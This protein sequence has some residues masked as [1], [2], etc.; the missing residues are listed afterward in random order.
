MGMKIL[1]EYG[2]IAEPDGGE[3]GLSNGGD[4]EK[5]EEV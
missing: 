2:R 5:A 1:K 3:A 4:S